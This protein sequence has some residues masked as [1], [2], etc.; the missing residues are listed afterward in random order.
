LLG[1]EKGVIQGREDLRAFVAQ[2]FAKE[3]PRRQRFRTGFSP[4]EADSR[5]STHD[6]A[7][8][9]SNG[10]RRDHRDPGWADPAPPGLLGWYSLKLYE[11][12]QRDG[13]LQ[14]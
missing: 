8:M 14:A 11:E 6:G 9:V 13:R 2:V 1:T 3:P 7:T 12:L 10:H 4:T 5:G